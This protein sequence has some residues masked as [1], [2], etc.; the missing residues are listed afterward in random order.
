MN[1]NLKSIGTIKTPYKD[2]APFQPV[3]NSKD[4]FCLIL[5]SKYTD[6]LFKLNKFKY[7]YVIYYVNRVKKKP[8]MI[9]SPSWTN[10]EEVGLFSS[11]SPVRPNPIALSVVE[12]KSI[13][14][15]KIFTSGLD[16]FDGT[17]IIDI[18][19]YIQD[20]DVKIDANYGWIEDL[21]DRD[22]LV[23]HIKGVPHDY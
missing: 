18:K 7:I 6:G 23:L 19:P 20:L 10:G 3:T 9:I 1:I 22:H 4:E 16:A 14:G 15:N 13:E 17:P 2:K 11:R 8:S 12:I 5:N 21:E